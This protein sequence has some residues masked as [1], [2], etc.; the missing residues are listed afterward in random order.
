MKPEFVPRAS[1]ATGRWVVVADGARGR[2]FEAHD[3]APGL[4]P[5]L[6]YQL[7][8]DRLR[9]GERWSDRAGSSH[10]RMTSRVHSMAATTDPSD[11]RADDLA[12]ELAEVL[13][14]ARDQGRVDAIALVAAPAFLGRLRKA[15]DPQT[16][17]LVV[18][19]EDRDLS[20]LPDHELETQ[21]PAQV[22][23][24]GSPPPRRQG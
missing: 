21:V 5:V 9:D 22:W 7:T 12:R 1:S 6:P 10:L 23:P 14:R 4:R 20:S 16:Y 19:E 8:A 18:A 24:A 11:Q 13:R 2:V 17:A 15:L 3:E